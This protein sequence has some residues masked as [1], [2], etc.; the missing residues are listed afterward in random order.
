MAEGRKGVRSACPLPMGRR[1]ALP[2]AVQHGWGSEVALR[3]P[4]NVKGEAGY[5][6]MGLGK[7]WTGSGTA[8]GSTA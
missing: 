2:E 5:K 4:L 8:S 6:E 7:I 1:R 3:G